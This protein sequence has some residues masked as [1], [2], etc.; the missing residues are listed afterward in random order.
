VLHEHFKPEFLNRIDDIVVFHRLSR[1]EISEDHRC[2]ARTA[3]I[4]VA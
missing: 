2:T 1:E 4:D 3:A